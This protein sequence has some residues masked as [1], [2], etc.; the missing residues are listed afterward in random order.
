MTTSELIE[1]LLDI[2][3]EYG[4]LPLT[5]NVKLKVIGSGITSSAEEVMIYFEG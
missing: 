2:E 5:Q 1:L 4:D 3:E